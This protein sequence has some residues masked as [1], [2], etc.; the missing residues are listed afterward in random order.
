MSDDVAAAP[1]SIR[2]QPETA[3]PVVPTVADLFFGFFKVTITG[4]GGVLAWARREF[5]YVRRWM[6]QDEFNELFA[7]CQFLPGPNI[8]TFSIVYGARIHG[9]AGVLAGLTGLMVPPIVLM[10]LAGTLYSHYGSLPVFSGAL[11]GL[12]AAAA[13]LLISSAVQMAEPM[14]ERRNIAGIGIAAVA[15]LAVG[16][17]QLPLLWVLLVLVPVSVA[18]AWRN[19]V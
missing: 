8:V 2:T 3:A 14:F 7:L 12:A 5:V 16:W 19:V 13:G 10:I 4:F 11:A 15:F 18:I 17:L 9:W 6:T 1:H